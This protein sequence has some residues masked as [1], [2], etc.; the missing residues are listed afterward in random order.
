MDV[1]E[2]IFDKKP[3]RIARRNNSTRIEIPIRCRQC[4]KTKLASY[5]I[6]VAVTALRSWKQMRLYSPCHDVAW[7]ADASEI[8]TMK[9][10]VGTAW[11]ESQYLRIQKTR[12]SNTRQ[13]K[14]RAQ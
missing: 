13:H 3:R 10:F 4:G 5:P 7:D 8:Q 2:R 12:R 11:L 9:K 1:A 6:I 14:L